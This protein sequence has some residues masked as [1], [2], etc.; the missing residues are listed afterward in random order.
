[1]PRYFM[2]AVL[3]VI[4]LA[5]LPALAHAQL[6]NTCDFDGDGKTD[7]VIFRGGTWWINRSTAGI[8]V[9]DWG[10][11]ADTKLCGD[12]DKDGK[13]D[14]TVW[15]GG[16]PGEAGFWVL[17]SSNG[18]AV[19][20]PFG[21]TGDDARVVGD[22]N[23]DLRDDFAVHRPGTAL[24]PQSFL[25]Y[26]TASG[27]AVSYVPWGLFGDV[28][29]PLDYDGDGRLD[30]MVHRGSEIWVRQSSN[31]ATVLLNFGLGTDL[32][33]PGK[34][35]ADLTED[36]GIFR[37]GTW[38]IRG[39]T[40]GSVSVR[41]FG[42]ATDMV[43]QGDWDADGKTDLA[44]WRPNTGQYWVNRSTAGL[45]VFPWG[46]LGDYPVGNWRVK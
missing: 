18:A 32:L 36:I 19:F 1:M 24:A 4:I 44:I 2:K 7:P 37:N 13:S 35:D 33:V 38:W 25:F 40:T 17:Q 23:G 42:F 14:V 22:Y 9:V 20:E 27:G 41:P 30:P 39:T 15:R 46:T 8:M 21:Q 3:C 6:P 10:L 11:T 26:R 43:T 16:A 12:Y 29:A 5:G 28:S 45:A 31:G 34:W